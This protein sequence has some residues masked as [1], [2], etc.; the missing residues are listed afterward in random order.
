MSVGSQ[1]L[2]NNGGVIFT[3]HAVG[4]RQQLTATPHRCGRQEQLEQS[5]W[6]EG[7][8]LLE[9]AAGR[10]ATSSSQV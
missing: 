9:L 10:T 4:Q 6:R 1:R 2:E 7:R 3:Q 5:V 8:S